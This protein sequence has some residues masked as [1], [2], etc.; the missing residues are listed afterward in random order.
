VA[1]LVRL[2]LIHV[3]SQRL[4]P[5]VYSWPPV[6][7]IIGYASIAYVLSLAITTESVLLSLVSRT[8]LIGVYALVVWFGGVLSDDDRTM[9]KRLVRSPKAAMASLAE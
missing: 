2:V 4:W 1:F 5:V 9:L 8:A 3:I 7:K 6:W